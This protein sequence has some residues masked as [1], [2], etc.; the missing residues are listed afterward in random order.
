[1]TTEITSASG[2]PDWFDLSAYGVCDTFTSKEWGTQLLV[3]KHERNMVKIIQHAHDHPGL[4]SASA[5][6]LK[7]RL[8]VRIATGCIR[9]PND[10]RRVAVERESSYYAPESGGM[11][12]YACVRPALFDDVA[13]SE[14]TPE[15]YFLA[16]DEVFPSDRAILDIDLSATDSALQEKFADVIKKYRQMRSQKN[17]S[18]SGTEASLDRLRLYRVLPYL[19]LYHWAE[20]S[21]ARIHSET[22]ARVLFP[23]TTWGGRFVRSTLNDWAEG[24]MQPGFISTLLAPG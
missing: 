12:F 3:R 20:L 21:E 8:M 14:R 23:D 11:D 18:K 5:E 6:E 10:Q 15:N 22:M 1:M 4:A 9:E 17:P 24:A 16:Y 19:D 2:L 7:T 13:S